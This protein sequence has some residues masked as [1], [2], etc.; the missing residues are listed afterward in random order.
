LS[1]NAVI[2]L[3]EITACAVGSQRN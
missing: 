3:R 1:K 2:S